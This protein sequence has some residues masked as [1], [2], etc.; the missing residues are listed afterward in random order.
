MAIAGP[1]NY[2]TRAPQ[3]LPITATIQ[4]VT[5]PS[6]S[7]VSDIF[8]AAEPTH[9]GTERLVPLQPHLQYS[10]RG[11]DRR[12]FNIHYLLSRILEIFQ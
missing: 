11:K 3:I 1:S 10:R 6:P 5:S 9:F 4:E 7:S 8:S 12:R 2:A